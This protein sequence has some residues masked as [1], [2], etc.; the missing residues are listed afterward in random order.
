MIAAVRIAC[1]AAF[2]ALHGTPALANEH[3]H[4]NLNYR[5]PSKQVSGPGLSFDVH[6]VAQRLR[7][8]V[9]KRSN[10]KGNQASKL[11]ATWDPDNGPLGQSAYKGAV[12][13]DHGVASGDPYPDS[14]I[15]WTKVTGS[16]DNFTAD[17]AICLRYQ[18]AKDAKFSQ[19]V[20]SNY[21]WTTSDIDF[22]VKVEARNLAPASYYW[23]RFSTCHDHE[24]HSPVGKLK[25]TPKGDEQ[26]ADHL[27]LA[28]FSCSNYPWGFFN[29]YQ[30]AAKLE[31]VDYALHLGD[32]LYESAGDGSAKAY[33]DGRA[34]DRVPLPNKEILTLE[35]YRTRH[36]QYKT[37]L[38]SRALL[39]N[40]TLIAVWDDHEV[41]DNSWKAGTADSNNTA[42]GTINGTTFTARKRAAVRAYFEY[43]PIR[44]VDTTDDLRIWR[45]F[46]YGKLADIH[47]LDTRNYERDITD[48]YYNTAQVAAISNDTQ[49]S[50]MGGKQEAW[51]YDEL[52]KSNKRG[53]TWKI[54]GQQI[55]VGH[56]AEGQATYPVDYDAWDGYNQNRD[57]VLDTIRE[58][59]IDNVLFL[60]G[61]SH[62]SWL[63]E[64]TPLESING[65]QYNPA[66]GDGSYAVEFAGTAVSSPSSYG[67]NLTAT[68]YQAR[69]EQLVRIN[70]GL[71]FAE[72]QYRGFF[73]LTLSHD[74]ALA[75]F[76]ATPNITVQGDKTIKLAEFEV[77]KGQNKVSRPFNAGKK[78]IAGAIQAQQVDYTKQKWNG[79]GFA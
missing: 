48:V 30:A 27:R 68:Q 14:A 56:I 70:K 65:T 54:V 24:A 16:G 34:I 33:G 36:A 58:N 11:D 21:A 23:Y 57:R 77:K 17:D 69:A 8:S 2:A 4:S 43:T 31:D 52:V 47:M 5:S 13:W 60:A 41:A 3:L 71:H 9:E 39:S 73:T 74:R 10:G 49:R 25:T 12:K 7:R 44:Q 38:G 75:A 22:T 55:I 35:D 72:G 59:N 64:L 61:D 79:T 63:N 76:Y 62:A 20:D 66:N 51:F 50:L 1:F 67:K 26:G 15:L 45:S 18:V 6:E 28:V 32:W 53:A 29:A 19:V 37:D 78:P 46:Q 40:K 42:Q